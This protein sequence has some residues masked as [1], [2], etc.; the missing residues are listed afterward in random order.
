MVVVVVKSMNSRDTQ[1][2][3]MM[4]DLQVLRESKVSKKTSWFMICMTR[5]KEIPFGRDLLQKHL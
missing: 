3:L 4:C 2:N 1:E 5:Q